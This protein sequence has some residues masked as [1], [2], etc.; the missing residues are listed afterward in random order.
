MS[1]EN[2]SRLCADCCNGARTVKCAFHDMVKRIVGVAILFIAVNCFA[3]QHVVMRDGSGDFTTI[4]PAIDAAAPGDTIYIGPGEY[5][6]YQTITPPGWPLSIDVYAHIAKANLS[7]IGLGDGDVVI[8][9][10]LAEYSNF[11]PVGIFIVT[12]CDIVNVGG[13]SFR[14]LWDGIYC[15]LSYLDVDDCEFKTCFK[16]VTIIEADGGCI[17]GCLFENMELDGIESQNYENDLVIQATTFR[18]CR[19]GVF[20]ENTGFIS[21][22]DCLFEGDG[23]SS[24]MMSGVKVR[25]YTTCEVRD[26]TFVGAYSGGVSV[27]RYSEMGLF[28]NHISGGDRNLSTYYGGYVYGSG[29]VFEGGVTTTVYCNYSDLDLHENHILNAGGYSV[30]VVNYPHSPYQYLNM[31]NNYWGT[32]DSSQIE[33]WINDGNDFGIWAIVN[34]EPF[35]ST[36]LGS[37]AKSWGAVKHLYR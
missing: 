24:D 34:F 26:C 32:S 35:S 23:S 12:D 3:G 6:E 2:E 11:S 21:V 10:P 7:I 27:S 37:E 18:G 14:N 16:G 17:D 36:P 13:V 25:E 1:Y 29:N 30:N 22:S 5:K 9:P 33:E 20:S 28:D 19:N 8:G 31:Q 4:Q 15:G